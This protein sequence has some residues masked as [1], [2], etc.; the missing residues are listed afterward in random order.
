MRRTLTLA[1]L[2]AAFFMSSSPAQT[3]EPVLSGE[4]W[5]TF[6]DIPIT[7][8]DS[9][10]PYVLNFGSEAAE[11]RL[12]PYAEDV[13]RQLR[14]TTGLD[15]TVSTDLNQD[16]ERTCYTH[17]Y[18]QITLGLK[19]SPVP[20][21]GN[22]RAYPCYSTGDNSAWG[23]WLFM[24]ADYWSRPGWF[25][26]HEARNESAIRNAVLHEVVHVLGLDHPNRDGEPFECVPEG[27]QP[28]MCSPRGGY[29]SATNGG[30]LTTYDKAGLVQLVENGET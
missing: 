22:S 3:N 2:V 26:G 23:G 30:T 9:T 18:H 10:Y 12:R 28:V 13:A 4:G 1:A 15:I 11:S 25:C 14:E 27:V 19:K 21:E 24:D 29:L 16:G 17:P 5:T 20:T 7:S 8:I 6:R